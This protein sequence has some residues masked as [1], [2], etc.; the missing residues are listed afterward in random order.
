MMPETAQ[1]GGRELSLFKNDQVRDLIKIVEFE[2]GELE[3]TVNWN[4]KFFNP[5]LG[6][7]SAALFS[8]SGVLT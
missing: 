1:W 7:F 5:D 8:T 6:L 2:G 4:Y 3:L